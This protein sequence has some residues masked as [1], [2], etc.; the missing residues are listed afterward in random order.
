M[1]KKEIDSIQ[2]AKRRL[3]IHNPSRDALADTFKT[4]IRR[5]IKWGFK[6]SEYSDFPVAGD[7]MAHVEICRNRILDK[8]LIRGR[9]QVLKKIQSGSRG[10]GSL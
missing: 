5:S 9:L 10:N 2:K 1:V 4:R 3:T 8:T 7:L 6:D